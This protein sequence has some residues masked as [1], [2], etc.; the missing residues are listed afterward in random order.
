MRALRLRSRCNVGLTSHVRTT[1]VRSYKAHFV[2]DTEDYFIRRRR[3]PPP[4]PKFG[5]SSSGAAPQATTRH[6]RARERGQRVLARLFAARFP[7]HDHRTDAAVFARPEGA[8]APG[9]GSDAGLLLD[10]AAQR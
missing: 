5:S 2:E 7:D 8:A 4:V 10:M 6:Q 1:R 3:L 9:Q